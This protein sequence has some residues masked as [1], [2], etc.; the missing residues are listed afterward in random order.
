[1]EGRDQVIQIPEAFHFDVSV[2]TFTQQGD[3]LIIS[4]KKPDWDEFFDMPSAFDNDFL[5]DREDTPPQ[6]RAN[7]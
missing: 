5:K 6:E 3:S 4:A 1:M 7:N 2:V